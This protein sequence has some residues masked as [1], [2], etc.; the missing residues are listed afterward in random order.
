MRL[1]VFWTFH[2]AKGMR[3]DNSMLYVHLRHSSVLLSPLTLPFL[4]PS[5]QSSSRSLSR[6]RLHIDLH[7]PLLALGISAGVF[8]CDILEL[9]TPGGQPASYPYV[10]P[11]KSTERDKPVFTSSDG[12]GGP[13]TYS[14][15]LH[16]LRKVVKRL[17]WRGKPP[18]ALSTSWL[19]LS[20]IR[21]RPQV[22][23]LRFCGLHVEPNTRSEFLHYLCLPLSFR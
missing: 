9:H 17:G 18:R 8:D 20:L 11:L 21:L 19:I 1:E 22:L 16:V 14:S 12:R 4:S 23:P 3:D 15:L 13:M 6:E 10:I 7:L 5:I 2:F